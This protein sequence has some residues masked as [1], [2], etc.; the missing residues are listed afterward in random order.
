MMHFAPIRFRIGHD[1]TELEILRNMRIWTFFLYFFESF[2]GAGGLAHFAIDPIWGLEL[3][4][5]FEMSDT[6]FS[7]SGFKVTKI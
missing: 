1:L 2:H 6:I 7:D 3:R 4:A 5:Y